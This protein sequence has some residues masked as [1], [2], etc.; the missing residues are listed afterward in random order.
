MI[1]AVIF[2]WAGTVIDYGCMA[3]AAVFIEVFKNKG[4]HLDLN[5]ARGPMGMAKIDHVRELFKI[6]RVRQEWEILHSRSPGDAD[7]AELY[8]QVEPAMTRIVLEYSDLVPG[9]SDLVNH[10][11]EK[12]IKIGS[13]TGYVESMMKELI[14]IARK[15]GFTPDAIVCSSEIPSGRPAPWGIY[16]NAQ[17]MNVY[18]LSRMVKIG[19]TVADIHE[20]LNANMWT[21]ACSRSGNELGLSKEESEQMDPEVLNPILSRARE[22]F[23]SA[24]AH[25]VIEGVWECQPVLD[26]IEKRM[27]AGAV[28]Y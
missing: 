6:N 12:G 25:Y 1:K 23:L 18:P 19:D 22:K 4:I 10:L 3:P 8:S 5:E 7:V 28:P 2:D 13:T 20:G 11:R 15:Q 27:K 26:D 21:I 24:G 14:P 17:K 16:L 9:V